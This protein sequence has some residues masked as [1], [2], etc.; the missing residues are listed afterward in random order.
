M[1]VVRKRARHRNEQGYALVLIM[2]LLAILV[3]GTITVATRVLTDAQRENEEEM[4]W[5]GR[6]YV[7]GIRL[8][9]QKSHRFA[10]SLEEL[11][12]PKIGVRYMRKAFK[13]PMNRA[14]G[15]WRLI[16]VG[17]SGQLIGSLRGG[18]LGSGFQTA[19]GFGKPMNP[20]QSSAPASANPP[21]SPAQAVG[22]ASD[23]NAPV[24]SSPS[25]SSSAQPA[26]LSD[27]PTIGGNIIGV[28]SKVNKSSFAWYN[29][30]KNYR[31][32]EFIWDPTV[33][34]LTG[35]SMGMPV[36]NPLFGNP[37]G[38][39]ANPNPSPAPGVPLPTPPAESNPPQP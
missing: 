27:S 21:D 13:D 2:F 33:D 39:N 34:P 9:Y 8:Y 15:S 12:T 17:P 24:P 32:F 37:G 7:R 29:G 16:Y 4:I 30:A 20:S 25:D 14:D 36:Q 10:G 38:A 11:T 22:A 5:R 23:P 31:Q 6:Q 35:R 19:T 28:G 18:M 3:L 1:T 26:P